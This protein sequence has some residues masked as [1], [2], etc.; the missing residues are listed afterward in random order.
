MIRTADNSFNAES[1]LGRTKSTGLG[2]CNGLS[3]EVGP[4]VWFAVTG[5]GGMIKATTCNEATEF[6]ATLL[7]YT[8]S[9]FDCNANQLTCVRASDKADFECGG[10]LQLR[11]TA[12]EWKSLS[13]VTYYILVQSQVPGNDGTAWMSFRSVAAVSTHILFWLVMTVIIPNNCD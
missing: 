4:G 11:S 8:G 6:K 5:T 9:T 3:S 1:T 13:G 7:V 2:N 12:V 10:A